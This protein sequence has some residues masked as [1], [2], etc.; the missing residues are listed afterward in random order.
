MDDTLRG[1]VRKIPAGKVYDPVRTLS[2]KSLRKSGK[3]HSLLTTKVYLIGLETCDFQTD[4][5][6]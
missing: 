4:D 2:S 1:R 5:L 6:Y 3:V